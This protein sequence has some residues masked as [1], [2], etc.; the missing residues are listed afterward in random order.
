MAALVV[1]GCGGTSDSALPGGNPGLYGNPIRDSR[2]RERMV[3]DATTEL[4]KGTNAKVAEAGEAFGWRLM[5]EVAGKDNVL[6]SPLSISTALSMTLNGAQG[7]TQRE[8]R[9]ALGLAKLTSAQINDASRT[10]GQL[11]V[12]ADPAVKLR[13]ANSIWAKQ[14][15]AFKDPFLKMNEDAYG[16][17]VERLD[18][19]DRKSVETINNWVK[20]ATEGKIESI[21]DSIKPED[22]MFLINAVYFRGT[23]AEP[24]KK[25][26]TTDA[27]FTKPDGEKTKVAMMQ[28]QDS[29]GYVEDKSM[30]A[31]ALPYG[32]GRMEML[33]MLPKI[34]DKDFAKAMSGTPLPRNLPKQEL[35]VKMPKF[36]VEESYDL[37]EALA[38]L[39][40]KLAFTEKADLSAISQEKLFIASVKHKTFME[41]DEE[42]TEAAAATS[43]GVAAT[44]M[45]A[46]PKQFVVDRPFYLAL[47]E[48]ETGIVLFLG[49]VGA[50]R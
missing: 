43:V 1:A 35:I 5:R 47:R 41:V 29:F 40:M 6:I 34:A 45:P 10:M 16:A 24:F 19:A 39:G 12:N 48:R 21:I 28:V 44:S 36:R 26:L 18:F 2:E 11:L 20:I 22:R 25:D 7:E 50:P 23:W 8:M 15:A 33:V 14:D 31:V 49:Y 4:G 32:N 30:R 37:E 42:G 46:E 3:A 17:R 9:E 13:I 38:K 27:D